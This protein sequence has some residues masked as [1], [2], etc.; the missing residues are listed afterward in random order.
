MIKLDPNGGVA[1]AFGKKIWVFNPACC[2][3]APGIEIDD[4]ITSSHGDNNNGNS[5]NDFGSRD[6]ASGS[7]SSSGSNNEEFKGYLSCTV[8]FEPTVHTRLASEN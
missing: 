4:V 7:S 8:F 2:T 1:V 5:D 3:L 6:H